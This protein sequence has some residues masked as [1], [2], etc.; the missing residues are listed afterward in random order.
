MEN[1]SENCIVCQEFVRP[2][3]E[4]VQC[5][6]CHQWCYRKCNTGITRQDYRAAVQAGEIDWSCDSCSVPKFPP[7]T[8]H[9]SFVECAHQLPPNSGASLEMSSIYEPVYSIES[10]ESSILDQAVAQSIDRGS[11]LPPPVSPV[12]PAPSLEESS[13]LDPAP[14]T[15]NSS[16]QPL[17]WTFE[18]TDDSTKR[19][20]HK[21]VDNRG[22]TYNIKRRRGSTTDWQCTVRPKVCIIYDKITS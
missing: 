21:L 22:Y 1:H 20:M 14:T 7:P 9:S 8:F 6:G 15:A 19:G 3:Q 18:I 11:E 16:F 12:Q 13:I 5:D 10:S 4:A 2:R 17:P